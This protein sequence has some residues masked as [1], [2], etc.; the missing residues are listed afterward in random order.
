MISPARASAPGGL[1]HRELADAIFFQLAIQSSLPDPKH[2]S[3]G[4]LVTFQVFQSLQNCL[5]FQF[6]KRQ[7]PA[8]ALAIS[9]VAVG[10][11]DFGRE[12]RNL[13]YRPRTDGYRPFQAVLKLP[14]IV[15][16][17]IEQQQLQRLRVE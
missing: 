8:P 1:L 12:I 11:T 3:C 9:R 17:T 6:C 10:M 14:Y 16:P 2:A 15:R 13:Y 7:D 4:Q 5:F